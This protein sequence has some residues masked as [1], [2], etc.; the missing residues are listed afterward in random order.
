MVHLT[1]SGEDQD[2]LLKAVK[3]W[4]ETPASGSWTIVIDN[5]DDIELQFRNYIPVRRGEILFTTRDKRI[6]GHPG[7]VSAGAGVE[8]SKM[9]KEEAMATFCGIVGSEEPLLCPATGPLLTHLD[10]LPLAISQAATYIRT[11][12]MPTANYLALFQKSEEHQ[13]ALLSEPL[14]AAIRNDG[15][16]LSRAVMTTWALSVQKIEQE[17]PLS[18][19]LLQIMSFLDPDNLPSSLIEATLSPE[20]ENHFKELAPLL[21]FGLLTCLESSKYRLHRL[22]GM[23]A[24]V[25]MSPELKH[26]SIDQAIVLMSSCFPPESYHN[27]TKYNEILPHALSILDHVTSGGSKFG[28]ELSWEL[29]GNVINFLR[30]IG[31]HHLA[32][33]YARLS[34]EQEK[35]FEQDESKRY[36][37]RTR[38]AGVYYLM[39]EYATATNEYRQAL[40]GLEMALGE[41]HPETLLTVHNMASVYR[42]MG[43]NDKALKWYQRALSGREMALGKDHPDTLTT[44]NEMALVFQNQGEYARAVEWHQ[45]ALDGQEM[46]FGKGHLNTLLTIHNMALAFQHKGE[47]DKAL[48]WHQRALDSWEIA[49]GKDHPQ[50]LV[51]V[52]NMALVFQHKGEYDK[53]LEWYQRTLDGEEKAFGE[54]HPDTLATVHNM[55]SIYWDKGDYDKA[56]DWYQRALD[57]QEMAFGNDHPDTLTTV[58][59]MAGV[60]QR[61]GEND[62][63]LE[64]YQRALDGRE[65]TLGKDHPSTL[66]TVN[67]MAV[68]F[69]NKEEYARA[70]EWYQRVLDGW[71]MALGKDHPNTLV[72]IH[73]MALVYLEKGDYDKALEWYHRTLDGEEKALG[74][75]H[76]ETLTTVNSIA[77]VFRE[78]GEYDKALE[79]Y[80]RALDGQE[81]ALGKDHPD[82]IDTANDIA[83]LNNLF[84]RKTSSAPGPHR[85]THSSRRA[86]QRISRVFNSW[87]SKKRKPT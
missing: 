45:R 16:D 46:A 43:E 56:L 7:L 73:N 58:N 31:Q 87:G 48:E 12:H 59:N 40:D 33:K 41:H 10:G 9:G 55:A 38:L 62:K 28:S 35:V 21:N 54:A 11:T 37:S 51:A 78:K 60:F 24:R 23:W 14:P 76:P 49:L 30:G 77:T 61:K 65:M 22:V 80:Q 5:M 74:N 79:W 72:A 3:S 64:W 83:T 71:E 82:T 85:K 6:I 75:G 29:Q 18:I 32:I 2:T 4:F 70:L 39:A 68:V 57:G 86:L 67:N 47:Y 15:N 13:Q 26:Q 17:S 81:K 8:V 34:L 1:A 44:V 63:A 25:K 66:T 42:D 36:I 53:A 84:S 20:T 52:N 50:T 19:K 69:Q 27:V